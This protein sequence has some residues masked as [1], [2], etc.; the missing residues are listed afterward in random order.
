P[1]SEAIEEVEREPTGAFDVAELPPRA[2]EAVLSSYTVA[3][4]RAMSVCAAMAAIGGGMAALMVRD[5]KSRRE[6]ESRLR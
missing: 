1:A 3:F 4:H 6:V 2:E 5:Q